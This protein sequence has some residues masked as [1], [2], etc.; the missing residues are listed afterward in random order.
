MVKFPING[1][2]SASQVLILVLFYL[3]IKRFILRAP[4]LS[5]KL[6]TKHDG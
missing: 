6:F 1:G 3:F 2:Q 4:Q 5:P